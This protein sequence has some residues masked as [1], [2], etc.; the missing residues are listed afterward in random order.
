MR[1]SARAW[2]CGQ[3]T[4]DHATSR[5]VRINYFCAVLS[6]C[7]SPSACAPLVRPLLTSQAMAVPCRQSETRLRVCQERNEVENRSVGFAPRE[8]LLNKIWTNDGGRT[9]PTSNVLG[10]RQYKCKRHPRIVR[11]TGFK[12]ASCPD[13]RGVRVL[14]HAGKGRERSR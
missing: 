13:A 5:I 11:P 1:P 14:I 7:T 12:V 10:L 8:M 2:R 3:H 6:L 4:D 9:Q